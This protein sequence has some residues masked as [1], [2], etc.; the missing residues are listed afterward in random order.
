MTASTR[1]VTLSRVMPSWEGTGIVM[2]PL[3]RGVEPE[4]AQ[5]GV[6]ADD[7]GDTRGWQPCDVLGHHHGGAAQKAVRRGDHA[8]DPDWD[9][10]V[11]PALVADHDLLD[12]VGSVGGWFPVG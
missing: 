9:Q 11:G 4:V 7:R 6:T 10:A 5:V 12:R 1:T 8:P 3:G 2:I